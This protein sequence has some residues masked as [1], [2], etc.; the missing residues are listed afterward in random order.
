MQS[1]KFALE[2]I[3]KNL[4]GGFD[5]AILDLNDAWNYNRSECQFCI[6]PASI[7]NRMHGDYYNCRR[8]L[9]CRPENSMVI[10]HL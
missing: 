3:G 7:R 8:F 5:N 10:L 2:K 4:C 1:P 6:K 9:F